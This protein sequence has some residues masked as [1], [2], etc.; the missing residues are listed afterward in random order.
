MVSAVAAALQAALS[1]LFKHFPTLGA[2]LLPQVG[3]HR[4][5]REQIDTHAR[6]RKRLRGLQLL[7][8]EFLRHCC[9]VGLSAADSPFNTAGRAIRS[10]L[11]Q[12]KV[13]MLRTFGAAVRSAGASHLKAFATPG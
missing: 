9:A 2:W 1:Q 5:S 12:L 8:D 10:L 6:L 11:R 13:E 3:Q 7:H 4:V